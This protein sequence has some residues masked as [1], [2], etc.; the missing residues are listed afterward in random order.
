MRK[1]RVSFKSLRGLVEEYVEED[2]ESDDDLLPGANLLAQ[3]PMFQR[4]ARNFEAL[5]CGGIE[6]PENSEDEGHFELRTNPII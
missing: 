2:E 4:F 6:D 5:A 3:N 1:E